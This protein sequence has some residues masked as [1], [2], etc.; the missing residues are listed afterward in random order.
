ML[1][2]CYRLGYKGKATVHGFRGTFSTILN[3]N[4]F[5]KDH[6]ERQL[7]HAEE[8]EVRG[9]YNAAQWL[10][11]RRKMMIWWANFLDVCRA[12][13]LARAENS[14]QFQQAGLD[15]RLRTF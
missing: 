13:G 14:A 9:A 6:I 8:D 5:N 11:Q 3:E 12:K 7:A 15:R 1:Y 10:P 2:L 4:D